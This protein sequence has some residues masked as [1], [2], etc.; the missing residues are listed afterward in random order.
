[1]P[2]PKPKESFSKSLLRDDFRGIAIS[3]ILSKVWD[4]L[5]TS[6]VSKKVLV[7]VLLSRQYAIL[8]IVTESMANL[9]AIELSKAFDKVNHHALFFK[10]MRRH[11]PNELLNMLDIWLS[12]CAQ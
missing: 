4:Q 9:C 7:V 3:P 11:I 8:L 12:G 2:I 10:L 1:V 5:E 6:L